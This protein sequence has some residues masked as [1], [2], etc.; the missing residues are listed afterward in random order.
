M[1]RLK[2]R[3]GKIVAEYLAGGT[4]YRDLEDK[5]GIPSSTVHRWVRAAELKAGRVNEGLRASAPAKRRFRGMGREIGRN[6]EKKPE[7][8]PRED[9]VAEVRELRER[10]KRS[11]LH[12][13]LLN[14]MIDIAE[15]QL[16]V[17]IRKKSGARR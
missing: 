6:I 12:L 11:D 9:L 17:P 5:Y 8:L 1:N 7:L 15:E 10:L 2:E 13:K 16:E 14:A 3:R 4:S